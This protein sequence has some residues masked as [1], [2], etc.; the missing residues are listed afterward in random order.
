MYGTGWNAAVDATLTIAPRSRAGA[1]PRQER[2][3]QLGEGGDVQLNRL[4]DPLGLGL[5]QRPEQPEPGIVD[6]HVDR[7]VVFPQPGRK[8]EAGARL[9]QINRLDVHRHVRALAQLA[10]QHLE[11]VPRA[12]GKH[13]IGAA[14][15]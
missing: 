10:G 6:E 7:E 2:A 12:G 14:P 8:S 11:L 5:V 1:H 3:R 15:G 9:R 4:R 13:Q